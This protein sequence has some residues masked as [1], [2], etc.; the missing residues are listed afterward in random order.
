VVTFIL[1]HILGCGGV[2]LSIAIESNAVIVFLDHSKMGSY[3]IRLVL[4]TF[5]KM[6]KQLRL[7]TVNFYRFKQKQRVSNIVKVAPLHSV[8]PELKLVKV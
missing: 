8:K 4:Q 5:V 1:P 6:S 7:D 2:Q 3:L